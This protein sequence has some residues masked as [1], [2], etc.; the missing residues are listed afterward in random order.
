MRL[1]FRLREDELH[2]ADDPGLVLRD[3][4]RASAGLDVRREAA[5]ERRRPRV[6]ERQHEADRCPSLDAVHEDVG[7]AVDVM[8]V[9]R[10]QP[11]D[12]AA[13]AHPHAFRA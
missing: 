1:I 6:R 7:E 8:R 13:G 5:P 10:V 12:P 11:F 4:N 3:E 2:G 9:E